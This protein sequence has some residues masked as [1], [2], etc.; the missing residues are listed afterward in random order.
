V[1]TTPITGVRLDATFFRLDYENQIIPSSVAG[2]IGATLTN[3]GETLHQGFELTGQLETGTL[4]RSEHD[5]RLRVAYTALPEAKFVGT[6]F[7][8]IPGFAQVN[9]SGNRLPYAPKHMLTASL[10]YIHPSGL[11]T[12]VE[13]VSVSSQFGDDLNT[14]TGTPDGQRG[15]IPEST[16]WNATMNYKLPLDATVFVTVKNLFDR[17]VVVDRSRGLLPGIPRL[18]QTGVSFAF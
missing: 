8:S 3:A 4:L 11:M 16:L 2:G 15:L 14:V 13:A 1:R 5:L 12:I 7:S 17:T 18:V 6:R 10:G 9:V